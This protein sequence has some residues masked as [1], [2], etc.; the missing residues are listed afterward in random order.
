MADRLVLLIGTHKGLFTF[1]SDHNRSDWQL[2]GPYLSGGDVTHTTLDS[3]TGKLY[4]VVNDPWFGNRIAI[5]A[6]LGISWQEGFSGPKFA[7]AKAKTVAGL[8]HIEPG[9]PTEPDV[10]FCGVDP[11]SLF[12]SEDGGETWLEDEALNDHPT[13]DAGSRG[14]A[15]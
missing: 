2:D 6:D 10:L 1:T 12:R 4:A 3:R 11:A 15:A 13:R 7:A 5:S 14:P 8:W 9:L